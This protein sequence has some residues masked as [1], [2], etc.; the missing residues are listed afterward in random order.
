VKCVLLILLLSELL[1]VVI[2]SV[3]GVQLL[4]RLLHLVG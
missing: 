4:W 2:A 1:L 3:L